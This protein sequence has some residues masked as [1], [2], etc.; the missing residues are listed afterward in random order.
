MEVDQHGI[1]AVVTLLDPAGATVIQMESPEGRRGRKP[2]C[3]VAKVSGPYRL[4]LS[5]NGKGWRGSYRVTVR[6][7][8]KATKADYACDTAL[9]VITEGDALREK[10]PAAAIE[11]YRTALHAWSAVSD[12]WG[13]VL[14]L[15]R[16][17]SLF[18]NQSLYAD[19][20]SSYEEALPLAHALGDERTEAHLSSRA[21]VVHVFLG[22]LARA[23]PLAQ[24]ALALAEA[25]RC[26]EVQAS[27]RNILGMISR[28]LGQVQDALASYRI[29]GN[30]WRQLGEP[31]E[32]ARV[33]IN[34]GELYLTLGMS[35]QAL[36][37][38]NQALGLLSREEKRDVRFRMLTGAAAALYERGDLRRA[39]LNYRLARRL[40]WTPREQM[41][42][43]YRIAILL[44]DEEDLPG[45]TSVL[46]ES[47]R[48]AHFQGDRLRE[49][50]SLADLAHIEDLRGR[51]LEAVQKFDQALEIVTELQ[52]VAVMAS[53]LFG[54]AEAERDSGRLDE[55]IAS[56][57]KSISL[58]E[59]M[60]SDLEPNLRIA[61]FASRHQYYELYVN[62]L[63]DKHRRYPELGYGARAFEAAERSRARS[64]LD[65][66]AGQP[67]VAAMTLREIQGEVLDR[68]SLLLSYQ[69]G[70]PRSTLWLVARESLTSFDLPGRSKIESEALRLR[71]RLYEGAGA[72]ETGTL[73]GMLLPTGIEPLGRKHLLIVPDGVLHLVPFAALCD[74]GRAP[75]V[76]HHEVVHLPSAS[77][78]GR[79]RHRQVSRR[80]AP[81]LIGVLADP[82]FERGDPRLVERTSEPRQEE[83]EPE[84]ELGIERLGRLRF[85]RKEADQILQLFPTEARFSAF[86][87]SASRETALSPAFLRNRILH[88]ATHNLPLAHPDLSGLV[89]SRYD[90]SGRPVDS[91]LGVQEIYGL[92]LS[93]DLVVLSACG[94]GLGREV[95]GEGVV[96]L[97][98]AFLHS[99]AQ[100]VM[101][102]LWNVRE[103]DTSEL[104]TR[105]YRELRGGLT[106]AAALRSAQASMMSD[107]YRPRSWAGFVLQGEP[108]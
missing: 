27:T 65:V 82:V 70:E 64:L 5:G 76:L 97:T 47:R 106:A 104:M 69:L 87:F 41:V 10:Q 90:Q 2:I 26:I 94:T 52:D 30:L 91:F 17:G 18:V 15:E 53:V 20:L 67:S 3:A 19:A 71:E 50:F 38:F 96:G 92:E 84:S 21:S 99:G 108:R 102:S 89:L 72:A 105:F 37:S 49:A 63:M 77:V 34:R 73:S 86:D 93:A 101:V 11:K 46:E 88:I 22:D 39:L 78:L 54:R 95:R 75:L 48:L 23:R 4:K 31:A 45:A 66:L 59:S 42:I 7:V 55:A 8:R 29:A 25:A 40:A 57:E 16:L 35:D 12:A 103:R 36:V 14:A 80:P 74:P 58:V 24:S 68:D 44:R 79:M 98:R 32:E 56:V 100:R 9:R 1:D 107:G 13:Q 62:L 83:R 43:L 28:G 81:G 85:T 33:L 60:R 6:E 51:E 61:F